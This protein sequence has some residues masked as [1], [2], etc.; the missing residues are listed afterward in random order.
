MEYVILLKGKLIHL[1]NLLPLILQLKEMAILRRPRFIAPD[2][3]TYET[4]R[5]NETLYDAIL[6]I[7]GT[8][9]YLNRYR[10]LALRL[11][12]NVIAL[13]EYLYRKV[14]SVETA[15]NYSR[16]TSFL[17][18]LNRRI[19][20]GLRVLSQVS[21]ESYEE[22][23]LKNSARWIIKG[24]GEV[25]AVR[26]YDQ[27]WLSHAKEQYE[28]IENTRV[29][30]E[31][32]VIQVGYTRGL[33]AWEEFLKKNE[34]RYL[35]PHVERNFIFFIVGGL[36]VGIRGEDCV[37]RDVVFEESLSVLKEFSHKIVT[38]FKPS[39]VT[40]VDTMK[41]LLDGVGFKNY[42]VSYAHPIILIDRSR[43]VMG[44]GP[45]TLMTD[46]FYRGKPTVEYTHYDS[47]RLVLTGGRSLASDHVSFFINRDKDEL[48]RVLDR[49]IHSEEPLERERERPKDEFLVLTP[50]EIQAKFDFMGEPGPQVL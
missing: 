32:P 50:E 29:E 34:S 36:G 38:V 40:E 49:L 11:L 39:A 9:R 31:I 14:I 3:A 33:Q 15:L 22:A 23:R 37:T 7:G 35:P 24:K 46:A 41:K 10:N 21:N 47:R 48:R 25:R 6:E 44:N 42:I 20:G 16:L 5:R 45:S 28:E 43:F 27:L 19:W 17:I 4:I 8:L 13:R 2:R 26:D 18:V 30:G 12:F 1:D